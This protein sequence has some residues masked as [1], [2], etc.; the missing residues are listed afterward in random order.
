MAKSVPSSPTAIETSGIDQNVE[1]E[2]TRLLYRSAGFG[3]FSNFA[4]AAVLVAGT[5]RT[6]P[7]SLQVWWFGSITLISLGRLAL[8][9][10]FARANP[11][12]NDH[13]PWRRAFNLGIAAAGSVWGAAG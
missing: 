5:L 4:L 2:M 1:A 9:V 11:A 6:H 10:A 3:L 7:G 8:N 12:G 13:L